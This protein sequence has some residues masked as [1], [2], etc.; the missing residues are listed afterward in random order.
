M[1]VEA[2]DPQRYVAFRGASKPDVSV[3]ESEATTLV[4]WWLEER[5]DGGTT[6]RLRESGFTRPEDRAG[7]EQ[8]WA[9]ELG[10]LEE[11]LDSSLD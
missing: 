5:P 11:L 10:E 7:N 4:E 3:E 9:E 1:R 8:G 2:V 6:L